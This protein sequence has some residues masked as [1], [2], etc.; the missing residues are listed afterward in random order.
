VSPGVF[1]TVG[2]P[3]LPERNVYL[4]W[5]EAPPTVVIE[6]TST[7]TRAIAQRRKRELYARLGAPEYYLYDPLGDY[8]QPRPQ[9]LVLDGGQY[10]PLEPDADGALHS[11]ALGLRLLLVDGHPT[12]VD[13]ATSER[14]LSPTERADAEARRAN[15][16]ERAFAEL[17]IQLAERGRNGGQANGPGRP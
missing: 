8:L 13:V 14:L 7:K 3:K 12:L 9:G 1:V 10:R 11:E 5:D 6:I 4:I 15:T 2:V 16:A 17:R